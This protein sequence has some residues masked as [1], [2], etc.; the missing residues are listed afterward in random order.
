[1]ILATTLQLNCEGVH[2]QDDVGLVQAGQ[3]HKGVG[4]GD[5]FLAQEFAVGS[6]TVDDQHA[7]NFSLISWQRLRSLSMTVTRFCTSCNSLTR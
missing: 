5:A 3:R 6:I 7:G 1:M 2:G 4:L